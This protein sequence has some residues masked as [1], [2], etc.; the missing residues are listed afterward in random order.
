VEIGEEMAA[1]NAH[2]SA[3]LFGAAER[4]AQGHSHLKVENFRRKAVGT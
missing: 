3:I 1:L 2:Q 4:F